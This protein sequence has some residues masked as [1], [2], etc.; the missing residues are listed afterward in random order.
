MKFRTSFVTNSSSSSYVCEICGRS[1]T[2]FD[3]GLS[4]CEMMECVNGH[5]FCCEE[6]LEQPSK[7]DMIKK[8]V[9][10]SD[11]EFDAC[12]EGMSTFESFKQKYE[13]CGYDF[14]ELVFWNVAARNVHLPVTMNE[15]NVKLVSGASDKIISMVMNGLSKTPYDFMM[16][17][18]EKY[19]IFDNLEL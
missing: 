11:M 8:I 16:E 15:K 19:K 7:E 18:L 9:I 10:I 12:A 4:D 3:M 2:G 17:S 5:I 14:P 13:F 6:A 1:E